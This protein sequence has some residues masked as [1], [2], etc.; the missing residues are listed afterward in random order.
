MGLYTKKDI[1]ID[2]SYKVVYINRSLSK[3]NFC[4]KIFV[5]LIFLNVFVIVRRIIQ[6]IP[7]PMTFSFPW[8]FIQS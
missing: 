3:Q 2:N 4:I 7:N 6:S 5:L 8:H 1:Q